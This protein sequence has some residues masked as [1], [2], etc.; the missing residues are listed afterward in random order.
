MK[1]IQIQPRDNLR[2]ASDDEVINAIR[3]VPKH[4]AYMYADLNIPTVALTAATART[5]GGVLAST[6]VCCRVMGFAISFNGAIST[7]TPALV[8]VCTCTFATNP[9]GTNSTSLALAKRDTGRPETIQATAGH[10]WTTEPTAITVLQTR[11]V[12]AFNG[13][14]EILVGFTTPLICPGGDGIVIRVTAP[15]TVSCSGS[16]TVEE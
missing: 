15:A 6:N 13:L 4:Y 9:P 2:D 14:W 3:T 1:P 11:Y 5:V 10:S 8:E 16:I 7:A 12:G